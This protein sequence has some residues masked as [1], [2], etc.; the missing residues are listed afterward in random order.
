MHH[1][2]VGKKKLKRTLDRILTKGKCTDKKYENKKMQN[3]PTDLELDSC[4]ASL[5]YTDRNIPSSDF[6]F[7]AFAVD[8]PQA[9]I[10]I[11]WTSAHLLL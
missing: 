2:S 11:S 10:H 7:H 6:S 3:K 5:V 1:A 8:F 9:K 4:S